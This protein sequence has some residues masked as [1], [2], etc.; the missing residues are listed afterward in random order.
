MKFE[1]LNPKEDCIFN[2]DVYRDRVPFTIVLSFIIF[3]MFWAN[4]NYPEYSTYGLCEV[5]SGTA[6]FQTR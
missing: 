5:M 4:L 2:V 3:G 1:N 6:T